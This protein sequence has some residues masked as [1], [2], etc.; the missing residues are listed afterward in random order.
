M[1]RWCLVLFFLFPSFLF[2]KMD[3]PN[4]YF[5]DRSWKLKYKKTK[6]VKIQSRYYAEPVQTPN[7]L[8]AELKCSKDKNLAIISGFKYC[9]INSLRVLGSYLEIDFSDYNPNDSRGY[10][11]IRSKKKFKIPKCS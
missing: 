11:T 4:G 1:K 8:T 6:I 7:L 2:A 9:G 5:K 10:C 3:D